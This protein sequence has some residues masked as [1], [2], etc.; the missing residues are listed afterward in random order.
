MTFSTSKVVITLAFDGMMATLS[1]SLVLVLEVQIYY[2]SKII[3]AL[4]TILF[5]GFHLNRWNAG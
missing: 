3:L 4:L 2:L 1:T 5:A